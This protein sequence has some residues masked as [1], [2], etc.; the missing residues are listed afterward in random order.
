MWVTELEEIKFVL[1]WMFPAKGLA[2]I[3]QAQMGGKYQPSYT[4]IN[5][6][7]HNNDRRVEIFPTFSGSPGILWANNCRI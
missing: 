3:V 4:A 6:E 2:L 1:T 7:N 5:H